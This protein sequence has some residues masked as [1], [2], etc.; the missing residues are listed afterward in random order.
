M[1]ELEQRK[2]ITNNL[3][4][5]LVR[6]LKNLSANNSVNGLYVLIFHWLFLGIP[7]VK[8]LFGEVDM[9]FM[10]SCFVWI[11]IFILH[12]YFNGCILIRLERK[13]WNTKEW[14]GPWSGVFTLV[15]M[16]SGKK[17]TKD[18]ANNMFYCWATFLFF[19]VLIKL[20]YNKN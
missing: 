2:Q 6:L 11:I 9:W 5:F 12:I 16:C 19:Y 8:I 15:E 10:I 13:L 4:N 18:S 14:Y 3:L 1:F 7:L 17:V 20:W